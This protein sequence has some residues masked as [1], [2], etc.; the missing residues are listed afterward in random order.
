MSLVQVGDLIE[1]NQV[2][3]S[4][5]YLLRVLG[6]EFADLQRDLEV[7]FGL[8]VLPLKERNVRQAVHH[9]EVGLAPF[10]LVDLELLEAFLKRDSCIFKLSL[11]EGVHGF[12]ELVDSNRVFF[13]L[14]LNLLLR[15]LLVLERI[16]Q[17]VRQVCLVLLS[18]L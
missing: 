17:V 13:G 10:L 18:I 11:L 9:H 8:R 6:N 12:L 15:L 1:G 4:F 16:S 7:L 14:N 2:L 3:L 5:E